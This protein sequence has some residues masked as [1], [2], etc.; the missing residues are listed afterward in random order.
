MNTPWNIS[1]LNQKSRSF[2]S[3][4]FPFQ[5]LYDFYIGEPCQLYFGVSFHGEKM[6]PIFKPMYFSCMKIWT[7]KN[8]QFPPN[9]STFP[10]RGNLDD[11]ATE[12]AFGAKL[13]GLKGF[14]KQIPRLHSTGRSTR[15]A[16][17][18]RSTRGLDEA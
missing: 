4:E 9:L 2:G 10:T 5:F 8:A 14:T 15:L 1:I 12:K 18:L 6:H 16:L 7:E 11:L 13:L 3:D 17:A